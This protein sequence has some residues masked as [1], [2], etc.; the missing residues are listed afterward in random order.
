M[1]KVQSVVLNI[2]RIGVNI[3][4]GDKKH[5]QVISARVVDVDKSEKEM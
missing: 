2:E 5:T 4:P 3:H 1:F